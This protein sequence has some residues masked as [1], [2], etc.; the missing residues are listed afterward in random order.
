MPTQRTCAFCRL[1]G[2]RINQCSVQSAFELVNTATSKCIVALQHLGF[3]TEDQ[4]FLD[5]QSWFQARTVTELR[6]LSFSRGYS[7]VGPKTRLV[8]IAL[9]AY[10]FHLFDEPGRVFEGRRYL[11]ARFM[12]RRVYFGAIAGA[13]ED[14]AT[15]DTWLQEQMAGGNPDEEWTQYDGDDLDDDWD[16]EKLGPESGPQVIPFIDGLTEESADCPICFETETNLAKT[17]CGH[18]FC[19]PCIMQHT[20]GVTAPC[21]CCRTAIDLFIVR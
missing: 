19:R 4:V 5:I 18:L 2:H 7:P 21:P 8:A 14:Q 17:N 11:S 9:L 15:S 6:L 12:F 16:D 1:P 10:Y 20:K 3:E 13:L